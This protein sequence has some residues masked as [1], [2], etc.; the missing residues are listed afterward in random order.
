MTD[1]IP[2]IE[3]ISLFIIGICK[4]VNDLQLKFCSPPMAPFRVVS[5]NKKEIVA[6]VYKFFIA[7]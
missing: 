5:E 7:I 4:V 1:F 6:S 3:A 2:Y